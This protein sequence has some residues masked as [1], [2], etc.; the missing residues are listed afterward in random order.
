MAERP[1][2]LNLPNAVITRI[3]KEA[4]GAGPAGAPPAAG[5]GGAGADRQSLPGQPLPAGVAPC[6]GSAAPNAAGRPV[7]PPRGGGG[8]GA[9]A[10]VPGGWVPPRP[11]GRPRLRNPQE[12]SKDRSKAEELSQ[13]RFL[14]L[15]PT[16]PEQKRC[17][18]YIKTSNDS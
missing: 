5:S 7:G 2:D 12:R 18:V 8:G 15:L 4:V 16:E 17:L 6:R 1:E 10:A 3:I 11:E 14:S 9:G 13:G